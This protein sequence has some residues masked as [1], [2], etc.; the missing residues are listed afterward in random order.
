MSVRRRILPGETQVRIKELSFL[1]LSVTNGSGR[2]NDV[3]ASLGAD[4]GIVFTVC[5]VPGDSGSQVAGL[6]NVEQLPAEIEQDVRPDHVHWLRGESGGV[7]TTRT[8][9]GSSLRDDH[10]QIG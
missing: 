8:Q 1:F 10:L 5:E 7:E 2:V 4:Q 6:A 3:G 9:L